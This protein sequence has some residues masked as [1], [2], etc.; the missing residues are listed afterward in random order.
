MTGTRCLHHWIIDVANG[1]VSK[2]KCRLCGEE[3]EF[4]N[5]TDPWGGGWNLDPPP[6]SGIHQPKVEN[7]FGG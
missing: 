3:R 2:G 1:P 6:Y 5:Y 4:S 7:Q